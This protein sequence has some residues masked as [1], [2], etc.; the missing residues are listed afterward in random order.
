MKFVFVDE[1]KENALLVEA[2]DKHIAIEIAVKHGFAEDMADFYYGLE[3]GQIEIIEI[4]EE[5]RE[6]LK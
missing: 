6:E 2:K 3:D 5:V 4:K 1:D